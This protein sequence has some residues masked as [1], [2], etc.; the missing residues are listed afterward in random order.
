MID[1]T[2]PNVVEWLQLIAI[3]ASVQV[4]A[5]LLRNIRTASRLVPIRSVTPRVVFEHDTIPLRFVGSDGR[6]VQ[7]LLR[8]YGRVWLGRT[9]IKQ[10]FLC[11]EILFCSANGDRHSLDKPVVAGDRLQATLAVG[12][13][14]SHAF[15]S[16]KRGSLGGELQV[17]IAFPQEDGEAYERDLRSVYVSAGRP[18]DDGEGV[19]VIREFEWRIVEPSALDAHP[20]TSIQWS[21]VPS[22]ALWLFCRHP[23]NERVCRL[24]TVY[25]SDFRDKGFR[26][27]FG[28]SKWKGFWSLVVSGTV[29]VLV[30]LALI[31]IFLNPHASRALWL[32]SALVLSIW[33][34]RAY[35]SMFLSRFKVK[36]P[37][38]K[39]SLGVLSYLG[40]AFDET[41]VAWHGSSRR[42][43]AIGDKIREAELWRQLH[44]EYW[45]P[46]FRR[47]RGI[48]TKIGR[49]F[50]YVIANSSDI[51]SPSGYVSD[52][53]PPAQ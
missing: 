21:E 52:E 22:S 33:L 10:A 36:K 31:G 43:V 40:L 16:V 15:V 26:Y 41:A 24:P 11:D 6:I 18:V 32:I 50:R 28:S 46:T 9:A 13:S 53:S 25:E 30:I 23:Y 47:I 51:G 8:I 48:G 42:S 14:E 45:E 17:V 19:P 1:Q 5:T 35:R 2:P 34:M 7:T 4:M 38:I 12:E 29:R 27:A 37:D 39:E 3:I 44:Y 20:D 49:I